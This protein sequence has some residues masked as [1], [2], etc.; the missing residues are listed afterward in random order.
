MTDP[1]Y[2]AQ[3]GIVLAMLDTLRRAVDRHAAQ[4]LTEDDPCWAGDLGVAQYHL[5]QALA[6]LGGAGQG[7]AEQD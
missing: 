6:I 2:D 5:E 4:T 1:A 7:K 3:L